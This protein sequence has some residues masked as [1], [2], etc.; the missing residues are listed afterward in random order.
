MNV[1]LIS[2]WKTT[3]P[4]LSS[5]LILLCHL[6]K[7]I[8]MWNLCDCF[9]VILVTS[10]PISPYTVYCYPNINLSTSF[11]II[12]RNCVWQVHCLT[13]YII[14]LLKVIVMFFLWTNLLVSMSRNHFNW[15]VVSRPSEM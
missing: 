12:C 11:I 9:F 4:A 8:K 5:L 2:S 6:E 1:F 13:I 7:E 15:C 3:C 14:N 10:S